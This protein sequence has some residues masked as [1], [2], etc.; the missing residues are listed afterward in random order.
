M[1]PIEKMVDFCLPAI[2]VFTGGYN[3]ITYNHQTFQVPK[4]VRVS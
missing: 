4:M 2:L 1:N 3:G